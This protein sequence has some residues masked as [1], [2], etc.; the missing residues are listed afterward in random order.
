MTL[1]F[2]VKEINNQETILENS[3]K[4]L[5]NIKNSFLPKN[6]NIND[7][8]IIY[9]EKNGSEEKTNLAKKILNTALN[10]SE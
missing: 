5:L 3:K 6:I 8:I 10:P 7:E 2:N 1:I 9:I 4:E